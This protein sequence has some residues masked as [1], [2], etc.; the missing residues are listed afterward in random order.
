[1][2]FWRILKI[3]VSNCN[4]PTRTTAASALIKT[5]TVGLTDVNVPD[6]KPFFMKFPPKQEN[7]VMI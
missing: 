2:T 7:R 1:M 5:K 3:A 6:R 4:Y